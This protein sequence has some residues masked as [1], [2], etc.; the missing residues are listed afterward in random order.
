MLILKNVN[1]IN[2]YPPI[3]NE[4]I[5][6]VIDKNIISEVGKNISAKYK[7][8]RIIDLSG[9]YISPG[10]VCSH[11]HFYSA[12]ARGIIAEMKPANNFLEILQNLWWKLDKAIDQEILNYSGIVSSLEAIKAGTTSVIDHNSSPNF[13]KGSLNTLKRCFEEAGLRGILC[14]EVTD[15]NGSNKILESLKESADFIST[16]EKESANNPERLIEAAIG[17]H[18]QFTLSDKTLSLISEIV[19]QTGKGIH[20]HI[21]EDKSDAEYATIN[22]GIT[23]A[24]RLARFNLLNE[25][26]ILAHGVHLSKKDIQ[27]I[28][29]HD[30]FLVHNPRSNMNNGVGYL[31][32]PG[33]ITNTAMG[34]DG[35]GSNML[36]EIKFAFFKNK[37][38][39]NKITGEIFL[40]FLQNGNQ[41]LERY[42]NQKLGRI[43]PGYMAD[44]V[45]YDY[46]PPTPLV[47]ENLSGHLTFGLSSHDVETVIIN[48]KIVYENRQF[49]FDTSSIYSDARNAAKKLWARIK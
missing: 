19:N 28:N 44:I 32:Y 30:S 8:D 35:I 34:T 7:A 46:L 40:K 20:I 23:A 45:V 48:G 39:K 17:A 43:A 13:I 33:Q 1:S 22:F 31:K 16:I 38:S 14:Y 27:L 49:P 37:E 10:L 11:N 47:N 15:R 6:V 4:D 2:F 25:K 21:C 29:E 9:K 36:E 5:D 41:I 26:S 18:A 42:F 24:E 12:L 3:I